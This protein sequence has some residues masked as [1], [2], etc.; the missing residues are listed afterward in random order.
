[1]RG[2]FV[3]VVKR[4]RLSGQTW[5]L[6]GRSP[7]RAGCVVLA[8]VVVAGCGGGG[9]SA[10]GLSTPGASSS[11]SSSATSTTSS[12]TPGTVSSSS[13]PSP[14]ATFS[15]GPVTG[16][17]GLWES[18]VR[19]PGLGKNAAGD[20]IGPLMGSPLLFTTVGSTTTITTVKP[21]P[22]G[23][24]GNCKET[25]APAGTVVGTFSTSGTPQVGEVS[26]WNWTTCVPDAFYPW[27]VSVVQDSIAPPELEGSL[28]S[29]QLS[30]FYR[31]C[32]NGVASVDPM[33]HGSCAGPQ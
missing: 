27:T 12:T 16:T 32:P 15:L 6:I 10:E 11:P 9:G 22:A 3:A 4:P 18:Y 5:R 26:Y 2:L 8:L 17:D 7:A 23:A 19:S 31:R 29:G 24:G 30:V 20:T 21:T 14:S 1:M 33:T 25:P 28:S 13:S